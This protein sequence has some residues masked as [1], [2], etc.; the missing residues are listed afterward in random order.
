L[1]CRSKRLYVKQG[2]A[3][4]NDMADLHYS[5]K[6]DETLLVEFIPPK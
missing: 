2:S 3:M 4:H 6:T 5:D 1:R